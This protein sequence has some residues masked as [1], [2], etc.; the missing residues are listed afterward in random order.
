MYVYIVRH[1]FQAKTGTAMAV[2]AVPMML[3]AFN[4]M[5]GKSR[6]DESKPIKNKYV[7]SSEQVKL[8]RKNRKY[9]RKNSMYYG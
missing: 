5:V 8:R 2:P 6:L 9:S 3:C 7:L 1:F 4:G